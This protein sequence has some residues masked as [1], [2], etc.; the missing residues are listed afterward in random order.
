MYDIA[1]LICTAFEITSQD[2]LVAAYQEAGKVIPP[3]IIGCPYFEID[4]KGYYVTK[5]GNWR[6]WLMALVEVRRRLVEGD[7]GQGL[8]D[9]IDEAL[10]LKDAGTA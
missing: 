2:E 5:E 1:G 7:R 3:F 6:P 4:G 10:G 8:I 9:V